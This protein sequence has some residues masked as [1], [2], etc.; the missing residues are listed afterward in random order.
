MTLRKIVEIDDELCDGCGQCVP[1]CAEGA[2]QIIDGKARIIADKL[3]DG[4]GACM[5][6]CPN[7]ALKIIERDADE[8]DEEAV[9]THLEKQKKSIISE[10]SPACGCASHNIQVFSNTE[11]IQNSGVKIDSHADLPSALTNWPIQIRLVPAEAPFLKNADLLVVADCVAVAFPGLHQELLAGKVVMMGCPKF[12]NSEEY[13]EK[14]SEVFSKSGVK[15]VT[16][17]SMEVPCC[18]GLPWIVKKGLE[19]S[20]TRIPLS[21]IVISA[22]GKVQSID[23][24]TQEEAKVLIA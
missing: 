1:S 23:E 4:L 11:T 24:N 3:C 19:K 10:P 20:G 7:D 2:L 21:E 14:F 17:A 22:Q 15:S 18:S 8:F 9:E 13:I 12:D 6:D 5:G 16:V